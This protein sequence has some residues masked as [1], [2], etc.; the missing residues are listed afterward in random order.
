MRN[1]RWILLA[2]GIAAAGCAPS[3]RNT[4]QSRQ[5]LSAGY[6]ALGNQDYD[7]AMSHAE[8]FLR[9]HP[10]GGPG[11]AEALYLEGRVYEQRAASDDAAGRAA[12]A[13]SDLQYARDT[14]DRALALKPSPNVAGLLHAGVANVA[15]FQEDYPTAMSEWALAYPNLQQPDSRAWVLYRIGVSQQRLGRFDQADRSF[16]SVRQLYPGTVPAERAGQHRGARGFYVQVGAYSASGNADK[17]VAS[18]Q[19]Q[20][21]RATRAAQPAGRQAVRV[22]PAYT[23]AEAK[24]LQSRLMSAYPGAIIEP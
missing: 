19:A 24:T 6:Q 17:A 4:A 15:Y 22:G 12:A 7:G 3:A 21:F 9:D 23:Y 13:K 5:E 11:T 20:G 16:D 1:A 14:Y 2:A 8:Q 10:N 18:L